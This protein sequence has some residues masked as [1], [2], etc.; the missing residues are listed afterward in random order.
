M[1]TIRF[2]DRTIAL[3]GNR[4]ARIAIG[5]VLILLGLLG[6]L[7]ILGFWM[8]PLGLIVLSVDIPLVRRW[9]RQATV[10]LG[11][12]L[13]ANYPGLAAKLGFRNGNGNGNGG[14]GARARTDT[15]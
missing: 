5:I 11:G 1:A 2:G 8:V 4:V 9:R 15:A 13:K 10:K 6:F 3:P 12:W 14:A 7:P